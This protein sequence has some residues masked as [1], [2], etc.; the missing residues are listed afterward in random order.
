MAKLYVAGAGTSVKLQTNLGYGGQFNL[1]AGTS[2]SIATGTALTLLQASTTLAGTAS[3]ASLIVTAGAATLAT[4][5]AVTT[6]N[7]TNSQTSLTISGPHAYAGAFSASAA[8]ITLNGALQLSGATSLTGDTLAGVGQ[9]QLGGAAT[10]AG[11][12]TL[13]GSTIVTTSAAVTQQ[14]GNVKLGDTAGLATKI[15]LSGAG[16][17]WSFA[18]NSSL[19]LNNAAASTIVNAGLIAKTGG[20]GPSVVGVALA[21]SGKIQVASGV[22]D[23]HGA[24][25]GNGQ[26]TIS[27][28]TT[29]A[30]DAAVSAGQTVS[31]AGTGGTLALNDY[32][33]FSGKIGGFASAGTLLLGGDWSFVSFVENTTHTQGALTLSSAGANHAVNLLGDFNSS[34]FAIGH[35]G[36]NTAAT[37]G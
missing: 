29:L 24:V 31:F 22:L 5:G 27:G 32:A 7:W 10:V 26:A 12:L 4:Q 34:L 6:A 35:A 11:G 25:T 30:F 13:G 3:G 14:G 28:A 1:G 15:F 33:E 18:D 19:V 20:T 17:S 8:T 21:N 9:L 23:L 36:G 37:Y 2:L 16:A